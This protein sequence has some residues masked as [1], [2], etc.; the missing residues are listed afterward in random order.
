MDI[1]FKGFSFEH[2]GFTLFKLAKRYFGSI[3]A[4]EF[5]NILQIKEDALAKTILY[6]VLSK[7]TLNQTNEKE[8]ARNFSK[9]ECPCSSPL[10]SLTQSKHYLI[11]KYFYSLCFCRIDIE[12]RCD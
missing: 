9:E 10:G 6:I 4:S 12:Y 11:R 3:L 1:R 8:C 7:V 2:V 5:I